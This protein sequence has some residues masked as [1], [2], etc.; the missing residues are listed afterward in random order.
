V[1]LC[2]MAPA[3]VIETLGQIANGN[4]SFVEY[5]PESG[6][7]GLG[8]FLSRCDL[9]LASKDI[10]V[11]GLLNGIPVVVIGD[12]GLGGL[13]TGDNIGNF[14]ATGFAGRIGGGV[15]ERISVSM[16]LYEL[17]YAL[18]LLTMGD[19]HAIAQFAGLSDRLL[20]E[21][22]LREDYLMEIDRIVRES[23]ELCTALDDS[24][25]FLK[26]RPCL[27]SS[28]RMEE[29]AG[30][31]GEETLLINMYTNKILAV[32]GEEEMGVIRFCKGAYP[33]REIA[34]QC[35]FSEPAEV[36]DFIRELWE[37][38]VVLFNLSELRQ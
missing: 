5:A 35:G 13:V 19:E 18:D 8:N 17:D 32:A 30:T 23:R 34:E 22:F 4:I 1:K 27:A 20:E 14:I 37:K 28:V 33:I 38:R 3:A 31:A 26:L 36:G 15:N 12:Q 25:S 2:I 11:N 9:L 21:A 24:A 16:L 6:D 10:A 29:G 7:A